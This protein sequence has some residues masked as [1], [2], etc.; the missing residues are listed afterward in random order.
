MNVPKKVPNA[1]K[2]NFSSLHQLVVFRV[3]LPFAEIGKFLS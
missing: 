3:A 1:P 2:S